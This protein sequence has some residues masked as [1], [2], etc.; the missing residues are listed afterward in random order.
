LCAVFLPLHESGYSE[1]RVK[2]NFRELGTGYFPVLLSLVLLLVLG[3]LALYSVSPINLAVSG[4]NQSSLEA[5]AA[6][7]LVSN[8]TANHLDLS[9]LPLNFEPNQGQTDPQVKFLARGAGYGVFLTADQAILSLRSSAQ[10][11]SVVRMQLAGA[12]PAAAA[13]GTSPLPG[14]SNYFIGNNPAKWHS[15][16][17][18][19]ARVR[20][21]SVY[22]GVDLVYYGNQGRLE[23]DF[24]VA[25]GA[26]PS[27]IGLRFHGQESAN[28]DAGGDLILASGGNEVRLKA[29]RIYQEFGTEQRPVAGRFALQQ[30]G[31]VGFELGAYDRRRTLVIDPELTYS[32]FFG[33]SGAESC[34]A[35]LAVASPPSGCPAI[36]I[37][38]S[39]NIYIAGSTTSV[40]LP[41]V[42]PATPP[43]SAVQPLFGGVADVFVTKLNAAGSA[44]LF[45]TYLGGNNV[46]YPAGV[47]VDSAFNVVVAG[48]T[49]STN[50]PT[51]AA[52]AF[53]A[54]ATNGNPH[55]F[56]SVL[57]P[58]GEELIYSTYLSGS[59]SE[60]ARGLALD[61]RNKI[62]VIGVTTSKDQP[63]ATHSFPATLGAIQVSSLGN[64]QFF[65][66]KIDPTLIGF[67]SLAYSTYFGGGN[68]I[69]GLTLGGAITVDANSNVYITGGTNFQHTGSP[70]TDFPILNAFQ[71]C[72]DTPPPATAP[73]TPPT[74][75]CA[76]NLTATDAFVAKLN[77]AAAAGAQLLYSSYLGGT[78]NDA[79][80]GI[81]VDSGLSAYIT[82]STAS[83]DM[84]VPSG[85]TPFQR[86]LD[87]PTNP[88]PCPAATLSDAFVAKVG[89]PCTGSTCTNTAVPYTYFSYLGGAGTDVGL[90]ITTDSLQGARVAGWTD[91]ANFPTTPNNHVQ[92]TLGGAVDAFV[93]RIDTTASS[94]VSLG[95]YSTYLGGT[96]N[97]FGTSIVADTQGNS[98][99]AGETSSGN[100]PPKNPIQANLN[101]PSDAFVT[102]VGPTLL[103][104]L[105]EAASPTTV[106]VGNNVT[107][108]YTITNNG[109]LTTGIIFTDVLPSTATFV[110]AASNNGGNCPTPTSSV[111]TCTVG[112][113]NGG[114]IG[115]IT[116]VLAPTLPA[117][118]FQPGSV[119][120]G[121]KI[122]IF[123]TSQIFTPAA[124]AVAV[125]NN[126]DVTVSPITATVAAGTPA[127]FT[128]TVN[129]TG[130]I[131]NTVT[132]SSSGAPTG[133]TATFP[134]GTSFTNLSSGPQSRQ[135]VVNTTARVTTPARLFPVGRPFYAALLPVSGLALLGAGIGG[136]KKSR[137]RRMLMVAMLGCFFALVL[138]QVACGSSSTTT[139]TTGTPAGTYNLTVTAT[140]GAATRTQQIVLVVQ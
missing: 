22:P 69:D 50:F 20:Y 30:D 37:D 5:F 35:I 13:A 102:K 113:L 75:N 130:N 86:C 6:S 11:S 32:T 79:G 31:S 80:F 99:V 100:F 101:G 7:D 110:S 94:T 66:S 21:Q 2:L 65:V 56:V 115:T 18:Q 42:P 105:T 44:I 83:A 71:G 67:P 43:P 26:D 139:T 45:S 107:F 23:Y 8:H 78:G 19:F 84:T 98:Y 127:S 52:S 108:T 63:D 122:S 46:D 53:Q 58:T 95:H 3:G 140:S 136:G 137:R 76:T 29:P 33:G 128:V 85:T 16:V 82:G 125:V 59:V 92:A 1:E 57:S 9:Q 111:L 91:S 68:P 132:L 77:P 117:L 70:A 49:T 38:P 40:D 15:G 106:G 89:T 72:L 51:S 119:G 64:S 48:T 134:N 97:D 87:N 103:M 28:L 74:T 62:Y 112:V 133:G 4:N 34:S 123:G 135:L 131:P 61:P 55:A 118:P 25:P 73:T 27:Q 39:S 124:P 138:F 114:Q 17:P 104:T 126:F 41:I 116:V 120:D 96:A 10:A 90:S 14:K 88:S 129:P 47:A 36:A 60:T 81:A 121:G 109:D 54:T 24:E 12:N 93:S